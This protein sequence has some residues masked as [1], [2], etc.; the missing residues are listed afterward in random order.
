[1]F[2]IIASGATLPRIWTS[3]DN[4]KYVCPGEKIY[5]TCVV[6]DSA[7]LTWRSPDYIGQ[8]ATIDFYENLDRPGEGKLVRLPNGQATLAQMMITEESLSSDLKIIVPHNL[9]ETQITCTD[10]R[11]TDVIKFFMLA[12]GKHS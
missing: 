9:N 4:Y 12:S 10:N 7:S 3:V 5:L 8:K 2:Y 11:G 1:M 6:G